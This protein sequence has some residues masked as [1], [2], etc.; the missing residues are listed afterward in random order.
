MNHLQKRLRSDEGFTLIELLVVIIIIGILLAIAVPSYLA[1]PRQGAGHGRR[2]GRPRGD[3]VGR[4]CSPIQRPYSN[5]TATAAEASYDSGFS[6]AVTV[7]QGDKLD[8]LLPL[9]QGPEERRSGTTRA[10]AAAPPAASRP[11]SRPQRTAKRFTANFSL[12][13]G[14]AGPTRAASVALT[15]EAPSAPT[16]REPHPPR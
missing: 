16:A 10:R 13:G 2:I 15:S 1:V 14:G 5:M 11:A 6:K 12:P 4:G 9:G 8:R 7:T 3:P